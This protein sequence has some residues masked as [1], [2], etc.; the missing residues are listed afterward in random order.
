MLFNIKS[1]VQLTLITVTCLSLAACASRPKPSVMVPQATPQAPVAEAPVTRPV[2]PAAPVSQGPLPGSEQDFVVNIGDRVYFDLDQYELRADATP[3]L[4][5]Q[6]AWLNRYPA[7]QVRIEGNADE[8]GTREYN[9]ALGSRRANSVRDY[10]ISR[11]VPASRIGAVS[12]GKERP[13]DPG[14][15]ES[16]YQSNRNART[17]VSGG[18]R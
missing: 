2:R 5:G 18:V 17:A 11:G 10:L 9:L 13:V 6:A 16:A 4:N 8:R 15:D 14:T 1:A 3:L 12:F 7:I